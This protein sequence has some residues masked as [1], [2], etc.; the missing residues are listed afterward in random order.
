MRQLKITKSITNR[1]SDSLD[2]YL[3]EIGHEELITVEEEV[4]L[5][6]R[7][8]KG[9]RKALERLTKANLRFVVSVAKQ[10]QNQGLSL[11]DLINE[12]NMGLIKAAEKFDETRGFKFI[13]YA[14]WWIRQSI[15][16]AIA[17]QS[18]IVRLPLNQVGSVNKINRILNKF[19]QENERRPSIDEIAEKT[20]L[21]EDKIEDAMKVPGKHISVD[22]PIVDGEENSLLDLL[23]STDTPT[24]DNELVLESLREEIAEALQALN[25][26][27]RNVIEAFFGINQQEMTL[28]EIG[29]KYGLT[30]ERVRQIKEKAIRRL[31][32]NTKNKM[33]KT[34]LGQ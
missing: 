19:E 30:R 9:D 26:R 22:A 29:D 16:Q 33:L 24:T 3:Q 12:G 14:V 13:S 8:R 17:E 18:R 20:D 32:H 25:E 7:I 2:K 34:Y 10:Y 28:E 15:L 6:Q 1:E 21:P 23:A 4:E 31:R 11:P 27:E 5:A